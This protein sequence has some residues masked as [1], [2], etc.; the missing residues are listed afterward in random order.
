MRII[1]TDSSDTIV[2]S[3]GTS[4]ILGPLPVID[5]FSAAQGNILGEI[6]LTIRT[7]NANAASVNEGVGSVSVDDDVAVNNKRYENKCCIRCPCSCRYRA[8]ALA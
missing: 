3:L 1:D 6:D 4:A 2:R 8:L 5:T 7:T